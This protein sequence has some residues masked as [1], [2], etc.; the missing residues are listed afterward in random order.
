MALNTYGIEI[1][2]IRAAAGYTVGQG[3][4]GCGNF[5]IFYDLSDHQVWAVYNVT[6]DAR[7]K[8]PSPNVISVCTTRNHITMQEIAD[9]IRDRLQ[10]L[11]KIPK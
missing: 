2:G 11:G 5:E 4:S 9:R 3:W 7:R 10:E 6:P 8:Y 1:K